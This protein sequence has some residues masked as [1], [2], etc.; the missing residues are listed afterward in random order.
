[1]GSFILFDSLELDPW[2]HSTSLVRVVRQLRLLMIDLELFTD[3]LL[4]CGLNLKSLWGLV[5]RH[6]GRAVFW[7]RLEARLLP[8]ACAI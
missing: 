8:C 5:S 2:H 3:L 6:G 1:M 7:S 4:L